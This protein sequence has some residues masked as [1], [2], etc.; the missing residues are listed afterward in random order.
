MELQWYGLWR[1]RRRMFQK[2]FRASNTQVYRPIQIEFIRKMLP[3]L[4]QKTGGIFEYN[5]AV[6]WVLSITNTTGEFSVVGGITISMTYGIQI[7]E[8]DDPFIAIAE[9]ALKS[10]SLAMGPGTFLVDLIPILKYVSEWIPGADFQR[11][12]RIWRRLQEDLR[13]RPYLASVEAIV[14]YFSILI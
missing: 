2:Y 10:V 8:S 12:A 1:E 7:K 14:F 5:Q 9:A 4:L 11:Q 3:R 13:E 6:S